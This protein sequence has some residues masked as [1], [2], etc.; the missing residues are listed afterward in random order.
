MGIRS[1]IVIL[2]IVPVLVFSL[3]SLI[4]TMLNMDDLSDYVSKR[5]YEDLHGLKSEA[6]R[7]YSE[8]A[9][10]AIK[11]IYEGPNANTPEAI[12]E[13]IE[14][15]R[16]LKYGEEGYI[17]VYNSKGVRV[18]EGISS[19][20]NG[21]NYRDYRDENGDYPIRDLIKVTRS[22][23][24]FFTSHELNS[25]DNNEIQPKLSYA[26]YLDKWDWH[27]GTG[28][29]IGNVFSAVE[30]SEQ[31]VANVASN[32]LT[33]SVL[34]TLLILTAAIAAVIYCNRRL[35]AA[36]KKIQ[37]IMEGL[38]SGDADLT[39]RIDI[40]GR[41]DEV[42]Q[43]SIAFNTFMGRLQNMISDISS[44]SKQ[45]DVEVTEMESNVAEARQII[46]AQTEDMDFTASSTHE[47]Q[48]ATNNIAQN[49]VQGAENADQA[50]RQ[51]ESAQET[52]QL[53][54]GSVTS[55]VERVNS[56]SDTI[57]C[58]VSD[59]ENIFNVLSVIQGIAEQTNLL[60]LNAAIEAARA[61]EQGRGF[62]V[63]ADEVRGL[64]GR[65][66]QSTEEINT[67]IANLQNAASEAVSVMGSCRELG[68]S[69]SA[70]S[71]VA[72]DAI[73]KII[74]PISQITQMNH[75]IAT[76]AEQQTHVVNEINNKVR[77]VADMSGRSNELA[78]N[79]AAA[80]ARINALQ[81]KLAEMIAHLRT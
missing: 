71:Q 61:G 32:T 11:D 56:A 43:A 33:T 38:A 41:R 2:S 10:T 9:Y 62:A 3:Y 80:G 75:Q 46:N 25:A 52:L 40:Q 17:F 50:N 13:A 29:Y 7:S 37:H 81:E 12:A 53:A 57:Q 59:V 73:V 21:L 60:A 4:S 70:E 78:E 45:L 72:Q 65:T 69:T 48:G 44:V 8:L 15:L 6:V 23:N 34:I 47:L 51:S 77:A 36:I 5:T 31:A 18:V 14:R 22:G 58:L 67:M 30:K 27:L 49:S 54:T 26:M 74:D 39:K 19:E 1:R 79:N 20:G 42:A 24:G 66:Q 64:A 76:A 16:Y 55:L 28:F 35:I 63:V 68:D